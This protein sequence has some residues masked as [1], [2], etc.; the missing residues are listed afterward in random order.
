MP[1]DGITLSQQVGVEP[2]DSGRYISPVNPIRLGSLSPNGF[3]G[4]CLTVAVSAAYHAT[5]NSFHLYSIASHSLWPRK[6]DRELVCHVENT[7]RS[8]SFE[9]S[10]ILMARKGDYGPSKLCLIA[11][12]DFHIEAPRSMKYQGLLEMEPI[13]RNTPN[14]GPGTSQACT[15]RAHQAPVQVEAERFRVC[16]QLSGE[17]DQLSA[18]AFYMDKGLAYIPAFHCGHR[19]SDAGACASLDFSLQ[20]FTRKFTL[21]DWN[22]SE[23]KTIVATMQGYIAKGGCGVKTVV[24][25]LV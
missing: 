6:P 20:L 16:D 1:K 13:T 22:I 7:R 3:G 21:H 17:A 24:C 18:L 12:A 5:C 10:T 14:L 23:Q 8:R 19:G 25:S 11:I 15:G 9:T 4:S 2:L